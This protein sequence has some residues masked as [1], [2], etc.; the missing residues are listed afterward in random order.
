MISLPKEAGVYLAVGSSY[1]TDSPGLQSFIPASD[2]IAYLVKITG[3][4]PYL[5]VDGVINA[6]SFSVYSFEVKKA[7]L[8]VDNSRNP[9][10][11]LKRVEWNA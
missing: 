9:V 6:N 10:W 11:F 2:D 5:T 8:Y 4:S 7:A 1:I 3:Q